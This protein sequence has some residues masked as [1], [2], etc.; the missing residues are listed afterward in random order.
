MRT[1]VRKMKKIKWIIAGV[2]LL[3][4]GVTCWNYIVKNE[5][6]KKYPVER[7]IEQEE[8]KQQDNTTVASNTDSDA[9][10]DNSHNFKL[11]SLTY[12]F[13]GYEM[14]EDTEIE[15]QTRYKAE[16][17]SDGRVP[18]SDEIVPE[19]EQY[20]SDRMYEDY[21]EYYEL[22]LH[23]YD[24]SYED[25]C[26]KI[27]D[28]SRQID[29]SKYN[30][31]CVHVKTYYYFVKMRVTNESNDE[32]ELSDQ[33]LYLIRTNEEKSYDEYTDSIIYFDKPQHTEGEDRMHHFSWYT[34][35]PNETLECIIGYKMLDGIDYKHPEKQL[36][37]IGTM[38]M[39]RQNTWLNQ[40]ISDTVVPLYD[41]P[42]PENE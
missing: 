9:A 24:Y 2:I 19:V 34:L 22:S 8:E 12:E 14:V 36:M 37:Y 29:Y 10:L 16:Y 1:K 15:T 13:L 23:R 17:F 33:S 39:E 18:E 25:Y 21:P 31:G 11:G 30:L 40:A 7:Y 3:V 4:A 27:T 26:E 42:K 5:R 28:I 20:D 35:Q 32:K 41:L 6:D 38:S